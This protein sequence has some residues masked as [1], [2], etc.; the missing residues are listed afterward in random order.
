[1]V[2]FNLIYHYKPLTYNLRQ[3]FF[4]YYRSYSAGL[5]SCHKVFLVFVLPIYL[6]SMYLISFSLFIGA[7]RNFLSIAQSRSNSRKKQVRCLLAFLLFYPVYFSLTP[8]RL[9][10]LASAGKIYRRCPSQFFCPSPHRQ[11]FWLGCSELCYAYAVLVDSEELF[12]TNPRSLQ[13]QH[14]TTTVSLRRIRPNLT[15]INTRRIH[16]MRTLYPFIFFNTYK[17]TCVAVVQY[18]GRSRIKFDFASQWPGLKEKLVIH[19][20]HLYVSITV[21]KMASLNS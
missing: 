6:W 5:F 19:L 8:G 10:R 13:D 4:V 16:F 20:Q 1:M 17:L 21:V 3:V 14:D 2:I 15:N 12:T 11:T 9:P 18:T 7:N